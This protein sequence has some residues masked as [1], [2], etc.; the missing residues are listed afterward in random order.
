MSKHNGGGE[1]RA[2]WL[3]K[4]VE[5]PHRIALSVRV[6]VVAAVKAEL[7]QEVGRS[8]EGRW[9]AKVRRA[10]GGVWEREWLLV[11]RGRGL[12]RAALSKTRTKPP[13]C[14]IVNRNPLPTQQQGHVIASGAGEWRYVDVVAEK[15]GKLEAIEWV[16]TLYAI[17]AGRCMTAGDSFND[18][19]MFKGESPAVIVGNAQKE[20]LEWYHGYR[21]APQ[22]RVVLARAVD[23]NGVLEGLARHGLL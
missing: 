12:A 23:A 3:D 5:H 18:V 10:T 17:P 11:G 9:G 15:G 22:G 14:I 1:T 7:E 20:L 4:G 8:S 13:S 2:V 6:D 19:E 21:E 16:R